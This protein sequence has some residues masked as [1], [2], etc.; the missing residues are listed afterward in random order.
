MKIQRLRMGIE[1]FNKVDSKEYK[2]MKV[3]GTTG[4]AVEMHMDPEG[5]LA[6]LGDEE[7]TI[8]EKNALAFRIL[9]DPEPYPVPEGYSVEDG[10]L[11]KDGEPA[12]VQGEFSFV[13]IL[14]VSAL[15]RSLFCKI[16][17]SKRTGFSLFAQ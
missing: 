3:D 13:K 5:T 16:P 14:L 12:C 2:V 8:T 7:I 4:T 17:E 6:G 10:V 15:Q 11:L 9:N 1:V